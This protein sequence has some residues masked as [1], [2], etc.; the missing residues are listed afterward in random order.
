MSWLLKASCVQTG[1]ELGSASRELA[2]VQSERRA[3]LVISFQSATKINPV[4]IKDLMLR[5]QKASKVRNL[6]VRLQM[7]SFSL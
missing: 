4:L 1:P 3:G 6:L 7:P 2:Q 5:H